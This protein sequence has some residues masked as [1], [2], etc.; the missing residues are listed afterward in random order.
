[1]TVDIGQAELPTL[2]TKGKFLMVDPTEVQNSR[3]DIMHMNG[4]LGDVPPKLI[5]KK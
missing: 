2:V 1:M 5:G 4:S 3:L